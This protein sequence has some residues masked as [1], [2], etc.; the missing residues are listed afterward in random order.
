M[1]DDQ[2][3][4]AAWCGLT[5]EDRATLAKF[6]DDIREASRRKLVPSWAFRMREHEDNA[7][8]I[9]TG[10]IRDLPFVEVPWP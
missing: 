3:A 10:E 7:R 4:R 1:T 6:C 5:P 8:L 2:M 9:D